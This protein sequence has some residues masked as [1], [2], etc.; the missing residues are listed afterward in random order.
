MREIAIEITPWKGT[1]SRSFEEAVRRNQNS[2]ESIR[3]RQASAQIAGRSVVDACWSDGGAVFLLSGDLAINIL[4]E[5]DTVHWDIIQK[6]QYLELCAG[7]GSEP[8]PV[9]L[10]RRV[11][12]ETLK[13][14]MDRSAILNRLRGKQVRRIVVDEFGAYFHFLHTAK[15]IA[16]H[17]EVMADSQS[18]FLMWF[19]DED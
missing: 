9:V 16:F 1:G 7:Y 13:D 5:K 3:A 15:Y 8:G 4:A 2:Q 10:V 17:G 19:E 6:A 18:S 11:K 12:N 14:E